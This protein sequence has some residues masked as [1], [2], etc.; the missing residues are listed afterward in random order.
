[1]PFPP[2][3]WDGNGE[4]W[5]GFVKQSRQGRDRDRSTVGTRQQKGRCPF[6]RRP[7]KC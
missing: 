1:M 4:Y 7:G 3:P 2:H 5:K 6:L